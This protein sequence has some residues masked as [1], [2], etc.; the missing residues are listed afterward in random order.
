MSSLPETDS[1]SVAVVTGGHAYD[2]PGF[3]T[4]FRNLSGADCYIQHM[5]DFV[6]DAGQVRQQYDVDLFYNMPGGAPRREV[7]GYEGRIATVL[8]EL[9]SGS[10]GVFVLHHG[11]LAYPDWPFWSDLV[12]TADRSLT[13]FHHDEELHVEIARSDHPITAGLSAWEMVD[14]TYVM[15]EPDDGNDI[16]LT[17]DHPRSMKAIGW[18]R[19]FHQAPVFCFQSGHD[20]QTYADPHFRRIVER[21]I[22][23][24]AGRL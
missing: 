20:D 13:S 22:Q 11:I 17:V 10:Q 2:V 19:T 24:C 3:H 7:G 14:E 15:A 6:S 12:G 9:G 21:G 1:A 5:E 16:L 8:E 23:W 4:L 18:T